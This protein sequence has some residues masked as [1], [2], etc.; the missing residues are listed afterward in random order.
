M[1]ERPVSC[2]TSDLAA[3][4][5]VAIEKVGGLDSVFESYSRIDHGKD[6]DNE[7]KDSK[8]RWYNGQDCEYMVRSIYMSVFI[9]PTSERLTIV[10]F[11]LDEES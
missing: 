10:C 6:E 7:K 1:V 11:P 5:V 9:L 8:C 3:R 4:A 2:P